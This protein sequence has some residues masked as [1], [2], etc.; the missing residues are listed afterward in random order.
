MGD[1]TDGAKL[2]DIV[3]CQVDHRIVCEP[4][5]GA[6]SS[7]ISKSSCHTKK[8]VHPVARCDGFKA[9]VWKAGA[10]CIANLAHKDKHVQC[11]R[12]VKK[13]TMKFVQNKTSCV[14]VKTEDEMEENTD[15]CSN[16]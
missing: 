3:V 1:E 7:T 16:L 4:S 8:W 6:S 15:A 11:G 13:S 5:V 10:T 12:K 14:A 2:F 9:D